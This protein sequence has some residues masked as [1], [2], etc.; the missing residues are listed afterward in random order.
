ML[1]FTGDWT[2]VHWLSHAYLHTMDCFLNK[3]IIITCKCPKILVKSTLS[4]AK[5]LQY[6]CCGIGNVIQW[7][8]L[9]NTVAV[10]II[11]IIVDAIQRDHNH[12]LQINGIDSDNLNKNKSIWF[13]LNKNI[14]VVVMIASGY[15]FIP[16]VY[17]M[18]Q[19]YQIDNTGQNLSSNRH[20]GMILGIIDAVS[21][22][23]DYELHTHSSDCCELKQNEIIRYIL[24]ESM[25]TVFA[26]VNYDE[27]ATKIHKMN[28]F[29]QIDHKIH[30][31]HQI[32]IMINFF[33]TFSQQI[34]ILTLIAIY[35]IKC[36]TWSSIFIHD[37]LLLLLKFMNNYSMTNLST[38]CMATNN[39]NKFKA[40]ISILNAIIGIILQQDHTDIILIIIAITNMIIIAIWCTLKKNI[41]IMSTIIYYR[42]FF[43][44]ICNMSQPYDVDEFTSNY[45]KFNN[46]GTFVC[47]FSRSKIIVI[48]IIHCDE[49]WTNTYRMNYFGVII[50][51]IN[52][53]DILYIRL[54]Y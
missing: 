44:N 13:T 37:T 53:L 21:R 54:M 32:I 52:K 27:F 12:K 47:I 31:L 24:D 35:L 39:M 4:M 51:I 14:T 36:Y 49:N 9:R 50:T 26:I 11:Y 8:I 7:W 38:P 17:K 25:N 10:Y 40:I 30:N 3:T 22:F 16:N 6:G 20:M 28:Q 5:R 1:F 41:T 23:S 29:H 15:K 34:E 18:H 42:I 19:L 48:I 45:S 43:A 46:N 2:V 33:D